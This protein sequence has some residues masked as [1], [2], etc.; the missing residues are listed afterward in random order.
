M[1]LLI[2]IGTLYPVGAVASANDYYNTLAMLVCRKNESLL[3][4]LIRLN[5]AIDKAFNE[6]IYTDVVTRW[7]TRYPPWRLSAT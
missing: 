6:D 3:Q 1:Y 2:T 7:P 5:Q 4:L